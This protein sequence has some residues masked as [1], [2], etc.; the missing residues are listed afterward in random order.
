[1]MSRGF[2]AECGALLFARTCGR[3]DAMG[4]YLTSLDDPNRYQPTMDIWTSSAT[5]WD[6]MNPSLQK[7]PRGLPLH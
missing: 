2:C 6:Y 3:T 1:M 4:I 5:K 7:T